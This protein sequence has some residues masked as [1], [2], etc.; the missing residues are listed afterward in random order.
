MILVIDG[1][2]MSGEI[3]LIYMSP[4]FT[5]D[6]S[7]LVQVMTAPSHHLSQCWPRHLSPYGVTRPRWVNDIF[8][9][10][11]PS[12]GV[13]IRSPWCPWSSSWEHKKFACITHEKQD[14]TKRNK[15]AVCIFNEVYS[16]PFVRAWVHVDYNGMKTMYYDFRSRLEC[17][18][19]CLQDYQCYGV[20][21]NETVGA[22]KE[23]CWLLGPT[24]CGLVD[25][26]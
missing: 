8:P 6:Q 5:D 2:G 4:D 12:V 24:D 13:I 23:N 18:V 16:C 15:I 11:F 20:I 22:G 14:K 19:A 7:T 26:M 17:S 21:F 25:C 10:S 9:D 3:A 1:W